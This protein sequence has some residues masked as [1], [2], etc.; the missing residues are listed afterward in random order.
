VGM[1]GFGLERVQGAGHLVEVIRVADGGHV[2][3][4]GGDVRSWGPGRFST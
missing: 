3:A 2:P 1:P 4:V